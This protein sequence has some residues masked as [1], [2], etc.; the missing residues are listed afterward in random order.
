MIRIASVYELPEP[1]EGV[2]I[3][4]TRKWPRG[5]P[6]TAVDRWYKELGGTPELL[7]EY[8]KGKVTQS[9]FYARYLAEISE[10]GRQELITH[11]QNLSMNGKEVIILCDA[12]DEEG[13][14][15]KFLK[16]VLEAY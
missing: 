11:L 7:K 8:K 10:P 15:R 3:L 4:V 16:E 14:V 9:G 13:S 1:E 6:K 2:R 12:E 5:V